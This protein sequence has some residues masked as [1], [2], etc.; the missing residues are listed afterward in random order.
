MCG[1]LDKEC[2][3]YPWDQVCKIIMKYFTLEGS[4]GVFYYYHFPLL[5]HF[6]NHDSISI[7]F[8][9]LHA[10][11]S[12]VK[13]VRHCMSQDRNF[14]IL[15]QGLIFQLYNFHRA[16]YPPKPIFVQPAPSLHGPLAGTKKGNK[17]TSK[18]LITPCQSLDHA[19]L[20]SPKTGGKNKS[21]PSATKAT[22][23]KPRKEPK[24]S[25]VES[26][27]ED[28]VTP[29]RFNRF[30]GKPRMKKIVARKNY[31]NE[32]EEDSEKAESDKVE[33]DM[34]AT[35]GSESSKLD[36][37]ASDSETIK[38]DNKNTSP[39]SA[40][41]PPHN[42]ISEEDRRNS[43]GGQTVVEGGE[44]E[45]VVHCAGC[46]SISEDLNRVKKK[47]D[48]LNSHVSKIAKFSIKVMHS[49]AT[50]M[51]LLHHEKVKQGGLE[52]DTMKE[53]FEFLAK[54]WTELLL[55]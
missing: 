52:G 16:L 41:S 7:P 26:N 54:D 8:F 24:I 43:E 33:D 1:G 10:L 13:Q 51:C 45:E 44:K 2:L 49:S 36:T 28:N 48:Y 39:S 32:G 21:N 3:P 31:V 27:A 12:T 55:S 25:L 46:N 22:S 23:K 42:Q 29:R 40:T 37:N 6:C 18:N 38:D 15:H 19:P 11:E 4:Y 30:L 9:L 5:N 47:L 20:I 17:K 53:L 14:T 35:K 50:S 34:E